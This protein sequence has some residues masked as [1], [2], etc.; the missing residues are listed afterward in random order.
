MVYEAAAVVLRAG[1]SGLNALI[2]SK[3]M[4]RGGPDYPA[5]KCGDGW[6]RRSRSDRDRVRER[7][8]Q[9]DGR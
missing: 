5:K 6:L 8:N 1:Y 3:W 4:L 7:K 9:N 2:G